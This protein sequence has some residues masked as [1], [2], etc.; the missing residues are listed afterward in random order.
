MTTSQSLESLA[1]VAYLIERQAIRDTIFRH[2]R[3]FDEGKIDQMTEVFT[4]DCI[5]DYG[6]ER[7]GELHG[8]AAFIERIAGSF[9]NFR[10]THHHLGESHI[11][12]DGEEAS[13]I[14]YILGWHELLNGE[15]C[16]V[17]ARYHDRLRR[18]EDG[19]WLIC[20]R[21]TLVTGAEGSMAAGYDRLPRQLFG[22]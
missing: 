2:T 17:G 9:H 15:R 8:R 14:S 6:P 19:R 20:Y 18:Q 11:E 16:W 4:E 10:W 1:A 21:R 5:T 7:G 3:Y 22:T 12:I 13:A